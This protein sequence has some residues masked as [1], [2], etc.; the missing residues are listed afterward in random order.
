MPRPDRPLTDAELNQRLASASGHLMAVARM[1]ERGAPDD[2]IVHQL[3]AV[4][5]ALDCIERPFLRRALMRALA[6][7]P[8][9][10]D[11]IDALLGR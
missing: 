4:R 2:Q 10:L 7:A 6:E 8:P 9:D 11:R 3:R 1:F 5:G